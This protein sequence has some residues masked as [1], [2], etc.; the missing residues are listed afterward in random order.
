MRRFIRDGDEIG[1]LLPGSFRQN[2]TRTRQRN[3]WPIRVMRSPDVL[4]LEASEGPAD[5]SEKAGVG[6]SAGVAETHGISP[7]VSHGRGTA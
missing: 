7:K 6:N 5:T 4:G 2:D 1:A 3:P